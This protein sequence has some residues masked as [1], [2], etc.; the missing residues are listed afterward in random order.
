MVERERTRR[1][2]DGGGFVGDDTPVDGA[3]SR[4]EDEEKEMADRGRFL[5]GDEVAPPTVET[6]EEGREEDEDEAL[7]K[8]G[9]EDLR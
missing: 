4:G 9:E 3:D 1:T 8:E 6:V 7:L 5:R 2:D